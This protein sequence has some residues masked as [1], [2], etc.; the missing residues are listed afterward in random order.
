MIGRL[1]LRLHFRALSAGALPEYC[2]AVWRSAMGLHLRRQVCLTGAPSCAGCALRRACAYGYV[3]ETEPPP[4]A[5]LL[6][7]YPAVPHPYALAPQ[8]GGIAKQGDPRVLDLLLFGRGARYAPALIAALRSAG[9]DGLGRDRQRLRLETIERIDGQGYPLSFNLDVGAC[10]RLPEPAPEVPKEV[11]VQLLSPLRLRVRDREL[12][13]ANF[14]FRPFFSAL[15]RRAT[16]MT[17]IHGEA[18]HL[19]AETDYALLVRHAAELI[20]DRSALTWSEGKR[21]SSRQQQ[22]IPTSG[23]LGEFSL[24]GDLAPVWPWLWAGQWLHVGKG[25]VM[26]L[27]SYRL[28]ND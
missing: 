12:R 28:R 23:L 27:G 4:D 3:M 14:S 21:W 5:P 9:A 22:E 26:G 25:A 16:Q 19:R 1:H 24:R 15:L 11:T 20:A 6:R 8:S 18:Q 7:N 2:G 17:A 10:A 13:P